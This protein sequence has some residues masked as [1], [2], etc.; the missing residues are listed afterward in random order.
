MRFTPDPS[1][2]T[3]AHHFTK[4]VQKAVNRSDSV[5]LTL[6]ALGLGILALSPSSLRSWSSSRRCTR[7][8]LHGLHA[9][10]FKLCIWTIFDASDETLS[11]VRV[12]VQ[13]QRL[14]G[15]PSIVS[16][17]LGQTR[18]TIVLFASMRS[19]IAVPSA[20][21]SRSVPISVEL[22]DRPAWRG[23]TYTVGTG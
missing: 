17:S 21:S 18:W 23:I 11:W 8:R 6:L 16:D 12:R 20:I 3:R 5:A 2:C 15:L 19:A 4:R 22:L 14:R 10:R 9:P 1:H 13:S 7:R